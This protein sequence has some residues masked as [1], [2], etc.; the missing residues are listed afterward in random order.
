MSKLKKWLIFNIIFI[1]IL[2]SLSHFIYEWSGYN[3]IIGIFVAVNESVWEHIKLAIFPALILMLIQYK[4]LSKN[5][6]FFIAHFLIN[7]YNDDFDFSNFLWISAFYSRYAYFRYFRF[8]YK[9]NYRS[10]CI[11]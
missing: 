6:N 9:C 4:S 10:N 7:I 5:H 3:K 1:I 2:G 11:L 8:Y